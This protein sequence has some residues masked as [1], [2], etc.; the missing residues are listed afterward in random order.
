MMSGAGDAEHETMA[1]VGLNRTQPGNTRVQN[2]GQ[3]L[4]QPPNISLA[5]LKRIKKA[6]AKDAKRLRKAERKVG[7]IL[8]NE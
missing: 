1:G 7:S 3:V 6:Q 4:P 8:L 2:T 5:D